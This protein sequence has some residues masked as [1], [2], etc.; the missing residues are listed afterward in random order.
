MLIPSNPA[1][2]P[3]LQRPPLRRMRSDRRAPADDHPP[4][5]ADNLLSLLEVMFSL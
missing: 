3:H 4:P 5:C 2:P 1:A